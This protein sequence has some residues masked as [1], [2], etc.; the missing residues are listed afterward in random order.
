MDVAT[1]AWFPHGW[2]GGVSEESSISIFLCRLTGPDAASAPSPTM[3][4]D[5]FPTTV[6]FLVYDYIR[7]SCGQTA[8]CMDGLTIVPLLSNR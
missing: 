1:Q 5:S 3:E 8:H 2:G 6:K 7:L 4:W